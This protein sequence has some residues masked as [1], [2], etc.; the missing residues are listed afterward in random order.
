MEPKKIEIN[1]RIYTADP[2]APLE[3]LDWGPRLAKELGG[4]LLKQDLA[5]LNTPAVTALMKEAI[6]R[7]WTP[8]NQKLSEPAV[9]NAW[10]SRHPEDLLVLGARAAVEVGRDFLPS[11]LATRLDGFQTWP[12]AAE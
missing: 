10:F 2:L 9:F 4:V 3:A 5:G 7:C 11:Q 12:G 8:E 1:G 6:A